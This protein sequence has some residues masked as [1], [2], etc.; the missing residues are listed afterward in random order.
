MNIVTHVKII[1]KYTIKDPY[2]FTRSSSISEEDDL[3]N[4]FNKIT[5]HFDNSK[6]RQNDR[7]KSCN[8]T[9]ITYNNDYYVIT[10]YH[11]IRDYLEIYTFIKINEK[12]YKFKMEELGSIKAYDFTV[13]IFSDENK[14]LLNNLDINSKLKIKTDL[15]LTIDEQIFIKYLKGE[16]IAW[17]NTNVLDANEL[18]HKVIFPEYIGYNL[19]NISSELYPK[20]PVIE[21][22][23]PLN[24]DQSYFGLSGSLLQSENNVM[25]QLSFHNTRTNAFIV[26]PGYCLELFLKMVIN[27][28]KIKCFCFTTNV[29][30]FIDNK[31]GHIITSNNNIKYKSNNSSIRFKINDIIE[32][33]DG[34]SFDDKGNLYSEKINT[35][36]PLDTFILLENNE[37]YEFKYHVERNDNY[38][39]T[40]KNVNPVILQDY[41][42]IDLEYSDSIIRYNG[43]VIAEMSEQLLKYYTDKGIRIGGYID[44]FYND[45]YGMDKIIVIVNIDNQNASNKFYDIY[46]RIGLPLVKGIDEYYI[47]VI[48]KINKN[49][50][51]NI[52]DLQLE[53]RKSDP[54][55]KLEFRKDSSVTL[56]FENG[57][58]N[59]K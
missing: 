20:I 9:L 50:I 48:T 12:I 44:E 6:S 24:V 59:I 35:Y 47:P 7:Y 34:N 52:N 18:Q 45:C 3:V 14:M 49:K 11:G 33:I 42:K 53:L 30:E 58:I 19:S 1:T 51:S 23:I 57:S 55:F 46:K 8:A 43:L 4:K 29:C 38:T 21:I 22:A 54:V 26:I 41:I 2:E 39:E 17:I 10:C 31:T 16:Q 5:N 40:I 27:S 56:S 15:S 37:S 25:G 32:S 36:V 28:Q 13:L